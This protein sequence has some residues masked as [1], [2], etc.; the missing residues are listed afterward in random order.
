M[1]PEVRAWFVEQRRLI[2]SD[3]SPAP[4]P[5]TSDDT[6][7]ATAPQ[8]THIDL[9]DAAPIVDLEDAPAPAV[10]KDAAPVVDLEDA[11]APVV[12]LEDAAASVV[13]LEDAAMSSAP[14]ATPV[15][16]SP[17]SA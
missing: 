8:S 4:A 13:D 10:N 3:I 17:A 12:V 7:Y 11:A 2:L 14:A 6:S 9:E 15:E 1:D 16:A 5:A